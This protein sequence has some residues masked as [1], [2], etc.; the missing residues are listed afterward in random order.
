M[1]ACTQ[2]TVN[3]WLLDF[4]VSIGIGDTVADLKTMKQVNKIIEDV[5]LMRSEL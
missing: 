4:G 5:S 1:H 2:R 3:H